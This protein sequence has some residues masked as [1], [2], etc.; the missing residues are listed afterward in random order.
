LKEEIEALIKQYKERIKR[1]DDKE[2]YV[3][4]IDIAMYELYSKF[5]DELSAILKVE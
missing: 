3:D 5:I 2:G 1:I 4:N